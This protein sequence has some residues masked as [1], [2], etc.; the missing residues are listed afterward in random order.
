MRDL[1]LCAIRWHFSWWM[2]N[3][4]KTL[5]TDG[6]LVMQK[7]IECVLLI[8]GMARDCPQRKSMIANWMH[9]R[10][11]V[12]WKARLFV[13]FFFFLTR[14]QFWLPHWLQMHIMLCLHNTSN[15][16]F[17]FDALQSV[18][19]AYIDKRINKSRLL[20]SLISV[21]QPMLCTFSISFDRS[22]LNNA[23]RYFGTAILM[24]RCVH[25]TYDFDYTNSWFWR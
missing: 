14:N 22:R 6:Y 8:K 17:F 4:P 7:A 19:E 18:S 20:F 1:C 13:V 15:C 25:F 24:N 5:L 12:Q 9:N 11:A 23:L 10:L 16:F 3:A 2:K 21:P